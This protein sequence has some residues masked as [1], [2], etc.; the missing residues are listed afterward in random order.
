LLEY[1]PKQRF[2][3]GA[4]FPTFLFKTREGNEGILQIRGYTAKPGP[5]RDIKLGAGADIFLRYKLVQ[6]SRSDK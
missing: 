5:G 4:A 3:F 1:E 6:N 2:T